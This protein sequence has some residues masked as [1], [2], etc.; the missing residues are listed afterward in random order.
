M[1]MPTRSHVPRQG[2]L[3]VTSPALDELEAQARYPR[4]LEEPRGARRVSAGSAQIA[5]RVAQ[6]PEIAATCI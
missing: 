2:G 6:G 5:G 4:A 3:D 1:T